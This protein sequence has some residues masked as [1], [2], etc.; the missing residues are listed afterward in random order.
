MKRHR[1]WCVSNSIYGA[2][3]IVIHSTSIIKHLLYARC[4]QQRGWIQPWTTWASLLLSWRWPW[5]VKTDN[6]Q[7]HKYTNKLTSGS[8]KH[9]INTGMWYWVPWGGDAILERVASEGLS[10]Y[11]WAA[12]CHEEPTHSANQNDGMT[13]LTKYARGRET[14]PAPG[15]RVFILCPFV[16]ITKT[17]PG[18]LICCLYTGGC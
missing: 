11:V 10:V 8:S 1:K 3:V 2:L 6:K 15:L 5:M 13:E 12:T 16:A 4:F 9:C 14:G 7:E 17:S 18:P